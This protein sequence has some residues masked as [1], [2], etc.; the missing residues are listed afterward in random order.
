MSKG[1]AARKKTIDSTDTVIQVLRA[2]LV[3]L[4]SA[5]FPAEDSKAVVDLKNC[6]RKVIAEIDTGI[7]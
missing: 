6:L 2:T 5:S 1:K 4:E 7:R 3:I